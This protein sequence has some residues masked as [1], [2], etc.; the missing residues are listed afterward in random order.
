MFLK[1]ENPYGKMPL[2]KSILNSRFQSWFL[3]TFGLLILKWSKELFDH[4]VRMDSIFLWISTEV[5]FLRNNK[6]FIT[7][8]K[9][10]WLKDTEEKCR[11]YITSRITTLIRISKHTMTFAMHLPHTSTWLNRKEWE[12][13]RVKRMV[14]IYGRVIFFL[15]YSNTL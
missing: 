6:I 13:Q 7:N 14:K 1:S 12:N 2:H 8:V 11:A 10:L 4:V 15:R 5:V 3:K 9:Q